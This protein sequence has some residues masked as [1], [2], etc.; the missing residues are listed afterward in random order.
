M[1]ICSRSF[2]AATIVMTLIALAEAGIAAGAGTSTKRATSTTPSST[3][4]Y[5]VVA[6]GLASPRGLVFGSAGELYVAEQSGGA[7]AKVTPDGRVTRIADGFSDP[8]DIAIDANG[9]LYVADSS[10]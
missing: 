10:T 8:H 3:V 6:T 7:V 1:K 4:T 9:D 5:A 2:A